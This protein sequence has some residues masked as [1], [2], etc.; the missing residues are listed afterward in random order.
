MKTLVP[1]LILTLLLAACGQTP[2]PVVDATELP[3]SSPDLAEA[4]GVDSAS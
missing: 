2:A 3:A 1:F 4:S